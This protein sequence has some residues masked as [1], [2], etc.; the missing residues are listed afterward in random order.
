MVARYCLIITL[1][2]AES[3]GVESIGEVGVFSGV[4]VDR[5][6]WMCTSQTSLYNLLIAEGCL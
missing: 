5:L 2:A 3:L 4:V 6:V 1:K